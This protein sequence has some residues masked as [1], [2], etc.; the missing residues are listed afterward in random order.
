[1]YSNGFAFAIKCCGRPLSEFVHE[2][3]N[4]VYLPFGSDFELFLKNKHSKRA[5]VEMLVNGAK[6]YENGDLLIPGKSQITI[7]AFQPSQK[8]LRFDREG[9]IGDYSP[10]DRDNGLVEVSFR[11]EEYTPFY[12]VPRWDLWIPPQEIH[13]HHWHKKYDYYQPPMFTSDNTSW[14]CSS[15]LSEEN[16]PQT[17]G[18]GL[19][20]GISS[21][22]SNV[23]ISATPSPSF[24]P[25]VPLSSDLEKG[26]VVEGS[27][28]NQ[29]TE[30][31][32]VGPL[33]SWS[34]TFRIRLLG[35]KEGETVKKAVTTKD[36]RYKYCSNCSE[37]HKKTDN[38]CSKCGNKL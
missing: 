35:S 36:T 32:S 34:T 22:S 28:S 14:F 13:H 12:T 9:C 15:S 29:S 18:G 7:E 30:E 33:C 10:G 1:M 38:F 16:A 24:T 27:H 6:V 8:R 25:S 3:G 26:V 4:A 2:G 37:K 21:Y 17:R 20:A 19:S 5:V 23:N 31:I 11:L